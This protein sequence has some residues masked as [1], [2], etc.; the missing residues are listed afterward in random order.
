MTREDCHEIH[1]YPF[2]FSSLSRALNDVIREAQ[3]SGATFAVI[4]KLSKAWID[5]ACLMR[6]PEVRWVRQLGG[7]G[8]T[9][10]YSDRSS[11]DHLQIIYRPFPLDD[12]HLRR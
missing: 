6:F 2:F 9:T 10:Q 5:K 8:V 4:D 1:F 7:C 12:L 3:A 11:M